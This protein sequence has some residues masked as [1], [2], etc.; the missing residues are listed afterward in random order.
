MATVQD[1]LNMAVSMTIGNKSGTDNQF[2]LPNDFRKYEDLKVKSF[3]VTSGTHGVDTA[4]GYEYNTS[5]D[6]TFLLFYSHPVEVTHINGDTIAVASRFTTSFICFGRNIP[7]TASFG[8]A[9]PTT[10][11][12]QVE[13][14]LHGPYYTSSSGSGAPAI[15]TWIKVNIELEA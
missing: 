11:V 14:T 6:S 3:E 5:T 13:N 10:N 8:T 15:A 7:G 2:R 12:V 1:Y 4:R 9:A